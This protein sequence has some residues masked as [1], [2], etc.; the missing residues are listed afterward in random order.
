MA[1]EFRPRGVGEIVDAA[2]RIYRN[3]WWTLV[4]SVGVILLPLGFLQAGLQSLSQYA[5]FRL[6]NMGGDA[7]PGAVLGTL[8]LTLFGQVP[9]LLFV[10]A[11]LATEAIVTKEA[12]MACHGEEPT[13]NAAWAAVKERLGQIIGAG[14]LFLIM[15]VLGFCC[16]CIGAPVVMVFFAPLTALIL[17][18]RAGVGQA[19]QRS[20][21]LV[22]AEFWR[23]LG[24]M[25]VLFLILGVVG[26][27]LWLVVGFALGMSAGRD[28]LRFISAMSGAN[29]LV[30]FLIS[31]FTT[32]YSIVLAP[33]YPIGRTLIYYDLRVRLE[34]YDLEQAT[35]GTES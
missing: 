26:A 7:S 32:I 5:L 9:A 21:N 28:L 29:P 8:G 31:F 1:Y 34:G 11:N 4:K 22:K 15:T 20:F 16:C 25:L 27:A 10:L 2:F 33:L 35:V 24:V 19:I 18:E 17:I 3:H 6:G 12:A 30:Y 23:V 14:L 13:L